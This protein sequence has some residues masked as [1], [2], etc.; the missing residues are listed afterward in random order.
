MSKEEQFRLQEFCM[1][2]SLNKKREL[3]LLTNEILK[4]L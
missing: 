2:V 4:L 3:L 1:I